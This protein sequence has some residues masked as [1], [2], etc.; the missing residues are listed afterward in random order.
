MILLAVCL[1]LFNLVMFWFY[2]ESQSTLTHATHVSDYY[3]KVQYYTRVQIFV[4]LSWTH[5]K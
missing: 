3:L 4:L 5:C 2:F 1:F